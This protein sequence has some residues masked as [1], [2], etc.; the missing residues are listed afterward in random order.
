[1]SQR[2]K[3]RNQRTAF[4]LTREGFTVSAAH[5]DELFGHK[6]RESNVKPRRLSCLLSIQA[7]YFCESFNCCLDPNQLSKVLL[8]PQFLVSKQEQLR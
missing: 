6:V 2:V 3:R 4:R 7:R 8:H 1:M 5:S